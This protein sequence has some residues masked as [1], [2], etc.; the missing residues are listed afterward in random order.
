MHISALRKKIESNSTY[1]YI[2]TVWRVGYKFE[3]GTK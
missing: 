1:H 2:K 3:V